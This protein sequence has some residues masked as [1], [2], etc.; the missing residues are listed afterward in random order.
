MTR[1]PLESFSTIPILENGKQQH[2]VKLLAK[3]IASH[4]RPGIRFPG[5]S[6]SLNREQRSL[7]G[8][9]TMIELLILVTQFP[10][11]NVQPMPSF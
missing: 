6:L 4:G 9:C 5:A 10:I 11:I 2:G 1:I 7:T 8:P 3:N